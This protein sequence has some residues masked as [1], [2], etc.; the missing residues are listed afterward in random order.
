MFRASLCPSSG[1]PTAFHCLT[2][3][4]LHT[5]HTSCQPNL[6]HHNS[7]NTTDNY[8]QWNAVGSPDE[9][10]KDARNP[11][12]KY[13]LP[14]NHY[15]LYLVGLSFTYKYILSHR[16]RLRMINIPYTNF[17]QNKKKISVFNIVFEHRFVYDIMWNNMVGSNR[18]HP[19][20]RD[21]L[22]ACWINKAKI[23][24]LD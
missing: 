19:K 10:H 7:Y 1:D 20:I 15:L 8:R 11:L 22:I 12:R 18:P 24:H 5:A 23:T 21:M 14:I 6:H 17:I 9:G 4:I 13:W 2:G 16:N 3:N